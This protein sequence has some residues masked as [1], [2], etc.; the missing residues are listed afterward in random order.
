MVQLHSILKMALLCMG[1]VFIISGVSAFTVTGVSITPSGTLNPSDAVNVSFTVYAASGTAFPSY[2][3]LQFVS[4]LDE[5]VWYH[6]I[7]VNDVENVRPSVGGRT[8]TISGFELSYRNQDEVIVKVSLKGRVP[9]TSVPGAVKNLVIIQELDARGYAINSTI[10]TVNHLIGTPTPTPTPAYGSV[11]F[12]SIPSGA[13]IYLDNAYKGLTPLTIDG[14]PNGNHNVVFRLNN[15]EDATR[16]ITVTG[17]SLVMNIGLIP[18]TV[19]PTATATVT[20][21]G[22][23]TVQ[24]TTAPAGEYG[25]LSVTTSPPGAQVYVD[26]ELKGNTPATIPGLS[27]GKHAVLLVIPGYLDL[28]TT[29]VVSAGKTTEY[30]TAL[31]QPAK[32]PGFGVIATVLSIVGLFVFR[33]FRK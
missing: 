8:L 27:A 5:M 15:Y 25:S 32:T 6:T 10:V 26:G 1:I 13:N 19:T 12:T 24:P 22:T 31:T 17:N 11:S 14:V 18:L 20:S 16:V 9:Q 21:T 7:I 28:N 29:V 3:D 33:K 2:D 4:G 30:S 23:V